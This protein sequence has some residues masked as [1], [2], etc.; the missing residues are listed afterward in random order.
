MVQKN[1][2]FNNLLKLL[3]RKRGWDIID[4][5]LHLDNLDR[6]IRPKEF[7]KMGFEVTPTTNL[8]MEFCRIGI[9]VKTVDLRGKNRGTYYT[10]IDFSVR[11]SLEKLLSV[12]EEIENVLS[13]R[14]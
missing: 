13:E 2:V 6:G 3:Q 11:E 14:I 12:K 7:E 8:L 4:K 1:Y 5:L 9:V 10:I